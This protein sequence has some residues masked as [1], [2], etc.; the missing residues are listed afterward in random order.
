[1]ETIMAKHVGKPPSC[2]PDCAGKG[3]VYDSRQNDEYLWRRHKCAEGHRWSS[4]EVLVQG[5]NL[6]DAAL[7]TLKRAMLTE[8]IEKLRAEMPECPAIKS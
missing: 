2:C 5:R 1:M 4:V 8:Q 7:V 3:K 6:K